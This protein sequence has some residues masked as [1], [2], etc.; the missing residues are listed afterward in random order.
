MDLMEKVNMGHV[1]L[2]DRVPPRLNIL[3]QSNT[4]LYCCMLKYG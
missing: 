2:V 1:V 4:G 3:S